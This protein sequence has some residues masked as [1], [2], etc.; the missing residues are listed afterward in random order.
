[1]LLGLSDFWTFLAYILMFIFSGVCIVY[2]IVNWNKGGEL[3]PE[4]IEQEKKYMKEEL[5]ISEELSEGGLS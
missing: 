1:M 3:T 5:A 4:E 2:G